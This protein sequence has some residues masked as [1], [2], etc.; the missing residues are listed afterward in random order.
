MTESR[1]RSPQ[2]RPSVL[3]GI[4]HS[5]PT[6]CDIEDKG[7]LEATQT[8]S[9]TC[10]QIREG[11]VTAD[12]GSTLDFDAISVTLS[13][14][15][16][17]WVE[18][19]ASIFAKYRVVVIKS[20]FSQ[21]TTDM[22]WRSLREL[23]QK[24]GAKFDEQRVGNRCPGR[25]D[26]GSAYDTGHL[27]HLAGYL[28]ALEEFAKKGGLRL[29]D[30]LGGYKFTGG[31]GTLCLAHTDN[32]QPLHSDYRCPKQT[33]M[34]PLLDMPAHVPFMDL[35][36]TVQPLTSRNGAMRIIPG[37]PSVEETYWQNQCCPPPSQAEEP[38]VF[39]RSQLYPL[40]AGCG[41]LRDIRVWHG[42]VPNT[43]DEDRHIAV[44]KFCS[45]LYLDLNKDCLDE[46]RGVLENDMRSKL[47]TETQAVVA[48]HLIRRSE[49][50]EPLILE[51]AA[52]W[53]GSF[54]Y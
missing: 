8:C 34:L 42:G 18:K 29:L 6:A 47:A 54:G 7:D 22:V 45:N 16:H 10:S 52:R 23:Q 15:D 24:W 41:I 13:P 3:S 43:D 4:R 9:K 5:D 37:L 14:S 51:N 40:P 12:L 19:A 1:S 30:Q 17:S 32:W 35:M 11:S 48:E 46:G 25:Y 26:M 33:T 31:H 53:P 20:L 50:A 38:E 2:R 44:L 21:E 36:F 49:D 39:K 27:T 28:E